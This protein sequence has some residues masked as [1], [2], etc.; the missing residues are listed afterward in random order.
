MARILQEFSARHTNL[1]DRSVYTIDG[2]AR[3]S[4]RGRAMQILL[5]Q[6]AERPSSSAD[7]FAFYVFGAAYH[8]D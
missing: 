8:F 2:L 7:I 1:I 6:G 3:C 4:S 5:G